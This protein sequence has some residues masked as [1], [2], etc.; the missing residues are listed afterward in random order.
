M[1][2]PAVLAGIAAAVVLA[3][4]PS[5]ALAQDVEFEV[6]RMNF[7]PVVT[8][9]VD[10]FVRFGQ[11]GGMD[12][13]YRL[14]LVND[15]WYATLRL[16]PTSLYRW[17]VDATDHEFGKHGADP[18]KSRWR[19]RV[20][21]HVDDF[22]WSELVGGLRHHWG[23]AEARVGGGLVQLSQTRHTFWGAKTGPKPLLEASVAL[24][25][26]WVV[27]RCRGAAVHVGEPFGRWSVLEHAARDVGDSSV[28][29]T[30]KPVACGLGVGGH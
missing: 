3:P 9:E 10:S 17:D 7:G 27:V 6:G 23:P 1:R 8:E 26:R 14:G 5:P 2:L 29:R 28:R 15:R 20:R 19:Y 25:W 13:Y 12:T 24:R 22:I 16:A 18:R 4:A 30:I 21:G 11:D